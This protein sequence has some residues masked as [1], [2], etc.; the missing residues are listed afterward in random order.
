[1]PISI[2]IGN[3]LI[4]S[5]DSSLITLLIG[6]SDNTASTTYTHPMA[7]TILTGK[8]FFISE[9]H[10]SQS[11]ATIGKIDDKTY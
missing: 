1:M 3:E 2:A 7:S 9:Q 10:C 8:G 6:K 11:S 4:Y 5:E